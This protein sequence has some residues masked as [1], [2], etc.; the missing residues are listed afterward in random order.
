[1]NKLLVVVLPLIW[2]TMLWLADGSGAIAGLLGLGAASAAVLLMLFLRTRSVANVPD[3]FADERDRAR[4]DHAHRIAYWVLSA[5]IGG[6]FGFALARVEKN[7]A[8]DI[9]ITI[10]VEQF[11]L[12]MVA[13]WGVVLVWL[14][15]PTALLAWRPEESFPDDG[16]PG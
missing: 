10:P 11:P 9:P 12:L 6:L 3:R 13:L 7:I 16:E 4:R 5:P 15:L 1:M 14:A 2:L 8:R